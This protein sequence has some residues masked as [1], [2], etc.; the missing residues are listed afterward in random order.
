MATLTEEAMKRLE[1]LIVQ[2]MPITRH[3]EFSLSADDEALRASAPLQPNAN[4][5]GTAF[6]GS[7][8]MLAT[9][10][11][12]AMAYQVVEDMK[13][14]IRRRA[15]ILIQESDIEYLKPV[16]ENISV[17]CERPDEDALERFREMLERWGRA[18]L[19]LKCRIDAAGERAVTFIGRYVALAEDDER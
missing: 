4:H 14:D 7:L 13:E 15:E 8:S 17:V 11:G 18:R 5:M 3:L 19:D 10:T 1:E 9:L 2:E 6:G 16:C 12:W